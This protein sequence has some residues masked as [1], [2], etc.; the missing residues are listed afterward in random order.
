MVGEEAPLSSP[1]F[2][3]MLRYVPMH[4]HGH[5]NIHIYVHTRPPSML[6]DHKGLFFPSKTFMSVIILSEFEFG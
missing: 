2:K 6:K 5:T 4:T 1:A 3:C